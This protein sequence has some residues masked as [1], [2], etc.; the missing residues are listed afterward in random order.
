MVVRVVTPPEAEPLTLD[1][2][3]SQLEIVDTNKDALLQMY[4]TAATEA[5]EH[6]T[7]KAFVQRTLEVI[8]DSFPCNEIELPI[9]PVLSI[10]NVR[11]DDENG[12][13]Q[14]V[15]P[16]DYYLDAMSTPGWVL[17]VTDYTWPTTLDAINA[18]RVQYVAGYEPASGPDLGGNV[19]NRAKLCILFLIGTWFENRESVSPETIQEIPDMLRTLSSQLKVYL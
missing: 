1:E 3:K 10:V 14:T 7:N 13:E 8:L 2:V 12:V 4:L 17:P 6:L 16:A 11:Y 9:T 5:V 19:P 18:V 15:S